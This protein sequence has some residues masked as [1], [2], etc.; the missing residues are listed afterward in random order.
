MINYKTIIFVF[1]LLITLISTQY[2]SEVRFFSFPIQVGI[3]I[4]LV[5]FLIYYYF[6]KKKNN[7]SM[8]IVNI[9]LL[10]I[11][12]CLIRSF[13]VAS[14]YWE[15]KTLLTSSLAL[16][17]VLFAFVFTNSNI[18][19]YVLKKWFKFFVPFFFIVYFF[20]SDHAYGLSLIH[21][22]EPTRPY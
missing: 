12:I 15:W 14:N 20:V 16:S 11:F 4:I 9:Y 1:V 17:V 3:Q 19:Q 22:S 8:K 13:F 18:T 10:W 5:L 2:W 6:L 7:K 21:I